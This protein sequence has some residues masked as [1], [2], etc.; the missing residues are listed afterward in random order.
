MNSYQNYLYINNIINTSSFYSSITE[1]EDYEARGESIYFANNILNTQSVGERVEIQSSSISV[2]LLD[3]PV[4]EGDEQLL[5]QLIPDNP[6]VQVT[7]HS[8]VT[9]II[10]ENDGM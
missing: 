9:V 7:Q 8:T 4:V 2:T 5:L 3:D 1:H 6:R 10:R